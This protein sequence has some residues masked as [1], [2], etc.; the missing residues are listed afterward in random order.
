MSR[1]IGVVVC[2]WDAISHAWSVGDAVPW[3]VQHADAA[4]RERDQ[5]AAAHGGTWGL[6]MVTLAEGSVVGP[7]ATEALR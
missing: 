2:E 4:G 3:P 7:D 5:L 6:A 1:E